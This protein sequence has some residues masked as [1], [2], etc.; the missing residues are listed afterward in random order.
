[1]NLETCEIE[2]RLEPTERE[3]TD[4]SLAHSLVYEMAV[5]QKNDLTNTVSAPSVSAMADC[6]KQLMTLK[7]P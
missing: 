7:V 5:S 3:L 4:M 6:Y 1:M 2:K